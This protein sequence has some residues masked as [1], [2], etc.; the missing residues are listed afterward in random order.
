MYVYQV[1]QIQMF[2]SLQKLNVAI[3]DLKRQ[4]KEEQEHSRDCE[5]KLSVS[6]RDLITGFTSVAT[7][8]IHTASPNIY[9]IVWRC[10]P[11]YNLCHNSVVYVMH[12]LVQITES[13]HSSMAR[14]SYPTEQYI[15]K[16]KPCSYCIAIRHEDTDKV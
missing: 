9:N 6:V 16:C 13:G 8:Y 5:T 11:E 10:S 7:I 3:A 14:S 1:M 4:L 2:H 12:K 15:E